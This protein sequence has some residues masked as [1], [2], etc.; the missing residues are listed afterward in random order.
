MNSPKLLLA[1]SIV[2]FTSILAPSYVVAHGT[3]HAQETITPAFQHAIPNIP[4]KTVTSL[5][6]EY[7]PGGK[8]LSHRHGSAY[9]IAYV[10]SGSIRSQV[11]DGKVQE[12]KAGESW[13]ENP[14]AHHVI[15]ENAS[16]TEPAKLLAIFIADTKE[17][18]LV[19]FDK[20]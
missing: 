18:N 17:K 9:V 5:V 2:A 20:Q 6:V 14:G 3:E 11:D 12:F 1:V 19:V 16:D 4:G 13:T 10:L 15:S 8:S 7:K